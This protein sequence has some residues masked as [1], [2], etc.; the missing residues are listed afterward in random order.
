MKIRPVVAELFH[1]DGRTDMK[2][3]VAF[4]SSANAPKNYKVIGVRISSKHCAATLAHRTNSHSHR[5]LWQEHGLSCATS[6][7]VVY[8]ITARYGR[9]STVIS[10]RNRQRHPLQ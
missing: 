6:L 4:P 7:S 5:T 3:I 9:N 8:E 2:I 1:A 10:L